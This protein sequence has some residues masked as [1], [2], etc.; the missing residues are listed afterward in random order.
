MTEAAEGPLA[1]ILVVSVEQ[2]VAAPFATC[3]LADAGARVIKVERPEGDFAR[4]YDRHVDGECTWFIWLNRG[5]ES[6]VLDI[7]D[8]GDNALLHRIVARADVFVQNLAP[9]ATARAGLDS[10]ELRRRHPRLITCDISGYGESGP[11]AQMK[12][13][14]FLIQCESGI[15]SVTGTPES[16]SRVGISVCDIGAGLNA[17]GAILEA[18][19]G[20]HRTG[21]GSG[22]RVSLFDGMADWMTV[23]LLHLEHGGKAPARTGLSHA[24]IAPYGA[25]PVGDG[26]MVIAIQNEREWARFCEHILGDAALSL[27]PRFAGHPA[28]LANR[29]EMDALIVAVF[30]RHSMESLADALRDAGIAFGRLNDIPDLSAHPQLRRAGVETPAGTVEIV[31]PPARHENDGE[32][33]DRPL[34]PVPALGEQS[35]AI[36]GEFGG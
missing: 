28:R 33:A 23:P 25:Y 6:V 9:G 30:A 3:R 29:A 21:K 34:R 26:R 24:M 35:K 22:I 7:K 16:A 32:N 15:A 14:D 31:A 13:Y 12:A 36:R 10:D 17:Y 20:R 5:K 11:Y 19:V 27:D 4:F 18:V 8:A 1:G 2:A